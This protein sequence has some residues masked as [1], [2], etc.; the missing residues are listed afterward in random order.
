M[1]DL[2]L[3]EQFIRNAFD[4]ERS[5]DPAGWADSSL[6]YPEN[7]SLI[8]ISTAY[9]IGVYHHHNKLVENTDYKSFINHILDAE[10]I[11]EISTLIKQFK[12]LIIN[13]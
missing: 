3:Y 5:Q 7:L 11:E 2:Y 10:A 1:D 13:F 8:K 9:A 6:F 12:A 4:V